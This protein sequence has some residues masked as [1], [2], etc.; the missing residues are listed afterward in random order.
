MKASSWLGAL[1]IILCLAGCQAQAPRPAST[2]AAP[3]AATTAP[4]AGSPNAALVGAE[5]DAELGVNPERLLEGDP[6]RNVHSA[7]PPERGLASRRVPRGLSAGGDPNAFTTDSR[8]RTLTEFTAARALRP[9][10]LRFH[11]LNIGAGSCHVVECPG[12]TNV[13]VYDCGQ[14]APTSDDMTAQQVR[15]YVRTVIGNDQP[16]VVLSHA[17]ADH[18]NLV[19]PVLDGITPQSIWL[20]G[21]LDDYR[22]T[23]AQWLD[24][25]ADRPVHFGWRPGWSENGE[26]V[27]ELKCGSAKVFMLTVNNGDSTNANSL[28]LLV[29]HEAFT[30]VLSGDAEGISERS[31]LRNFPAKLAGVTVVV[32]SHHGARTHQSNAQ[33]WTEHLQAQTVVYSAGTSHGHP[34]EEATTRF[35][36]TLETTAEHEM[37]WAP[38]KPNFRQ[39]DSRRTEYATELSGAIVIETDGSEYSIECSHDSSC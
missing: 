10:L 22:G 30:L 35:Q 1:V 28:M 33:E 36:P 19:S 8:P 6:P 13:I 29:E 38:E 37:W 16:V 14:M 3:P 7:V 34:S 15:D 32:A 11:F 24:T 9:D 25:H 31:A 2:T 39:F 23:A 18:V 4:A 20:G 17:D 27:P 12:S 26:A 21:K 5:S